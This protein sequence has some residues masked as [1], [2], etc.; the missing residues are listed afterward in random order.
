MQFIV[1]MYDTNRRIVNKSNQTWDDGSSE[2][3]MEAH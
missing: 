2:V 1:H 3:V